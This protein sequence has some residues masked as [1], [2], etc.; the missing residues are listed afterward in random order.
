MAAQR[1]VV[2]K[3]SPRKDGNSA[4]LA[5]EIVAGVG[6]A[7]GHA[8]SFYLHGMDIRPCTACDACRGEAET[9]CVIHDDMAALYPELRRADALVLAGPV[10]WFSVSAQTKL[11]LDRCYALLGP[12]GHALAGKRIGIALT[13]ADAD[14]FESGAVNALRTFQDTFRYIGAEIVGMVYGSAGAAG[15]I[16]ADTELLGRARQLGRKLAT[17]R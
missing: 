5:D 3:G 10:Y 2:V 17:A 12:E 7:G 11:F 14:P 13:Y 9:D 6:E 8:E 16:R 1:V 4:A 15:E